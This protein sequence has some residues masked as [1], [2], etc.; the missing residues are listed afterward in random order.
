MN[1]PPSERQCCRGAAAGAL[2][3]A[4]RLWQFAFRRREVRVVFAYC[5]RQGAGREDAAV[6][7]YDARNP[8]PPAIADQVD[9]AQG[10]LGRLLMRRRLRQGGARLLC[11]QEDE[12]VLAFGW[13]QQWRYFRRQYAWLTDRGICLGFFW[14]APEARGRGLYGRLMA[15][16]IALCPRR[17][18]LPL[19][20]W[21]HPDNRPSLRGIE[22]AGFL[23]LG[24]YQISRYF[25]GLGNSHRIIQQDHELAE[26]G[27][28]ASPTAD[29]HDG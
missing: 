6:S 12:K 21:T 15:H 20:I 28:P 16:A 9:G 11:L 17:E 29:A 1:S 26:C 27:R 8:P 25:F 14:T 5:R 22:K 10:L 3:L 13:I 19:L 4:R 18:E 24:T 23:R 2:S 7:C